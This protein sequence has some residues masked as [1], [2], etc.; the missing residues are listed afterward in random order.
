MLVSASITFISPSCCVAYGLSDSPP[1]MSR[2]HD[3][4]TKTCT[5]LFF[6]NFNNY[7]WLRCDHITSQ[8]FK[9]NL[10]T[11]FEVCYII[12]LKKDSICR[13]KHIF[14]FYLEDYRTNLLQ[15]LLDRPRTNTLSFASLILSSALK[16]MSGTPPHAK[17]SQTRFTT[18]PQL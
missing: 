10:N 9:N 13:Y 12:I 15:S 11:R 3:I 1:N 17:V 16:Y 6:S 2:Q 18:I 5:V 14:V 8:F 4:L 7:Y